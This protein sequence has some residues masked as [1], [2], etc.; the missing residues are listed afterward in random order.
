MGGGGEGDV[1]GRK[2]KREGNWGER[3]M[4]SCQEQAFANF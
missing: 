3:K 4:G 1:A 2:G